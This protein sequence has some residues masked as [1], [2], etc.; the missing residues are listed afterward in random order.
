[1]VKRECVWMGS[2]DCHKYNGKKWI[3]S[4]MPPQLV[5]NVQSVYAVHISSTV[6]ACCILPAVSLELSKHHTHIYIPS[7]QPI[8]WLCDL[9][10]QLR[11]I[12]RPAKKLGSI[13][14]HVFK[15]IRSY[16][17]TRVQRNQVLFIYTCSKKLGPIYIHVLKEIRSNLYTRVPRN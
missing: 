10:N 13:Y 8:V 14:I 15:E 16:L 6:A 1:M 5:I 12:V 4:S 11:E 2:H 3:W 7:W 17:Y 9:H